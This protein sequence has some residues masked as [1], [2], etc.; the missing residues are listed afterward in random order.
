MRFACRTM[1]LTSGTR[2]YWTGPGYL[3]TSKE[4][5]KG[6][7]TSAAACEYMTAADMGDSARVA[8]ACPTLWAVR[9]RR[10]AEAAMA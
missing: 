6:A 7:P 5:A 1:S 4:A 3:V 10:C 8:R 9:A 2:G